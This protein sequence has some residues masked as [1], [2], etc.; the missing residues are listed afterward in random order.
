MQFVCITAGSCQTLQ[1]SAAVA[2]LSQPIMPLFVL[3]VASQQFD[4]ELR[5][6]TASLLSDVCHN[7]A[8][9]PRL[10]PL[11]GEFLTYRTAITADAPNAPSNSSGSLSTAYK[12]HEDIKKRAYGQR[13]RDVEGGV[14]T[15]LAFSTTGGWDAKPQLSTKDW[16]ICSPRNNRSCNP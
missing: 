4:N 5:D 13:I 7:V 11:S 12:K 1:S 16:Q 10:Q 14:F 2:Q 3:W 8:T 15:P 6:V 9:E